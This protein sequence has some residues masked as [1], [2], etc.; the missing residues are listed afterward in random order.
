MLDRRLIEQTD[1][2]GKSMSFLTEIAAEA[3]PIVDVV[4]AA[5]H[6]VT[7]VLD[8]VKAMIEQHGEAQTVALIEEARRDA[9]LV[10]KAI[11]A[12]TVAGAAKALDEQTE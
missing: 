2:R 8:R 10:G 9:K 1:P 12:G 11:A 6:V 4:D 5:A 3:E 7:R